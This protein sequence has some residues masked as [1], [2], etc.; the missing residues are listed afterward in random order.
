MYIIKYQKEKSSICENVHIENGY[1]EMDN[2]REP[3]LIYYK[4]DIDIKNIIE[5]NS[6]FTYLSNKPTTYSYIEYKKK[7]VLQTDLIYIK[8]T[9]DLPKWYNKSIKDAQEEMLEKVKEH[10]IYVGIT[11]TERFQNCVDNILNLKTNI[12]DREKKNTKYKI[13]LKKAIDYVYAQYKKLDIY[14]TGELVY[15]DNN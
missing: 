10:N 9:D 3:M 12:K 4:G 15:H 7:I 13:E 14:Y 2:V 11:N 8:E 1:I 6:K 5:N